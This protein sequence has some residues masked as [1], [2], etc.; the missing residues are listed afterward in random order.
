MTSKL[1][2]QF[3]KV[4]GIEPKDYYGCNWDGYC[5]YDNEADKCGGHCPYWSKYKNDYPKITDKVLLEL[6]C[7]YIKKYKNITIYNTENIE[8][9]KNT[10]LQTYINS[11]HFITKEEVQSLFREESE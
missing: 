7:F 2:E 9:L 10:V 3:F 4:F 5:P 11:K 6:I 1:E 8:V